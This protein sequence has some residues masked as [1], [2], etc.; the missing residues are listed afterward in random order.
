MNPIPEDSR[1]AADFNFDENLEFA[2][3]EYELA[4]ERTPAPDPRILQSEVE[5]FFAPGGPLRDA[6]FAAGRPYEF[7]PQQLEMS[8]AIALALAR[9]ENLCVEAPTGVGKSFAY[10]APLIYRSRCADR[11]AL[12]A[13][14]TINL[15]E[16]LVNKDIPL[17]RELTGINF[18]AALAKGRNNYLCR[19]RLAMVAGEQRDALLPHPSLAL[20]VDRL[21]AWSEEGGSGERDDF[22]HG[23][24]SETWGL[25]GC[26]NGNCLGS[27][28]KY[29][30]S[31]HYFRAR[32]TWER[33]DF[34]VTNHA[35]FLTDLGMRIAG[36]GAGTLLPNY[37]TVV[38]DE[39]HTIEDN[40]SEHLGLRLSRAGMVGFL[41]RLF[42]PETGRGLLLRN[43]DAALELR[44]QI[45][46]VRNEVYGFFKP[47][48][49]FLG[50]A[51]T[52]VRRIRE[53]GRFPDTLSRIFGELHKKLTAYLDLLPPEEEIVP[54]LTTRAGNCLTY[55]DGIAEFLEMRK[56]DSVYYVE[57]DRYGVTLHGAPLNVAELLRQNLFNADF[58]VILCSATLTVRKSFDY[59]AGRVGY[60]GGGTLMLDSPFGPDQARVYLSRNMP[61]PTRQEYDSALLD[62]IPRFVEMTHGKAFVLFTSFRTLRFCADRL[63]DHFRRMGITLLRQGEGVNRTQLLQDFKDDVDSVLFGAA[64]FWTGVDVPGD[65]LSN[66]IVT[67][68]PFAVPDH[69]LIEARTER[70]EQAGGNSFRDY[71]LPEAVLKFRQGV[72]RLIRSSRDRGIIVV[73]DRRVTSRGYGKLFLDALP[74][75]VETV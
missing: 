63:G 61:E 39:A 75:P 7:R 49:Q 43:G 58:P 15:Q 70:I 62:E 71:S 69:P 53:P 6:A 2:V 30:R 25:V 8:G 12:V 41:N 24:Q 33:A 37:G 4:T 16:Q 23:L 52:S 18:T 14:A 64:S 29:F 36:E 47:F 17:L 46:R 21:E 28:C 73:L 66:V 19:R 20:D 40:A 11:P 45:A 5:A 65:A 9:G 67:K 51:D 22:P 35:L 50:E 38:I 60:D 56:P 68:L 55:L 3:A 32:Q 1:P 42:N 26:E 54:E 57:S 27:K 44:D 13:T 59:F 74:Y 72:G 48:E 10:L 34:L 31:C